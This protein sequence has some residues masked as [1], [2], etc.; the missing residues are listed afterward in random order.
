MEDVPLFPEAPAV[1]VERT[2]A[3]IKPDAIHFADEIVQEIK[4]NG[5]TILQVLDGDI[6]TLATSLG[7]G[8]DSIVHSLIVLTILQQRRLRLSPEQATDF[9][10][11]HY[12]KMFFPSLIAF[13][14]RLARD[15]CSYPACMD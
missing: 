15:T 1:T 10:S 4:S 6:N 14:H 11:E 2:L 8:L 9:Y 5:F 12:G 3:I 13:M 7:W